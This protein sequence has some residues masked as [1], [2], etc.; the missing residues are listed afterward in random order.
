MFKKLLLFFLPFFLSHL[1]FASPYSLL[2]DE[3]PTSFHN[4]NVINGQLNLC[5]QDTVVKGPTPYPIF[6]TYTS[7]NSI[8]PDSDLTI[9]AYRKGWAFGGGWD[10]L[11]HTHILHR[12]DPNIAGPLVPSKLYITEKNGNLIEY[13][14]IKIKGKK[15]RYVSQA[16]P[17]ISGDFSPRND[18]SKNQLRVN[19]ETYTATLYR[20]DGSI[21]YFSLRNPEQH[22]YFYFWLLDKEILPNKHQVLYTYSDDKERN[23]LSIELKNP[24]GELTYGSLQFNPESYRDEKILSAVTSDGTQLQYQMM[25]HKWQKYLEK[26]HHSCLPTEYFQYRDGRKKTGARV[27]SASFANAEK[28]AISYYEPETKRKEKK[29]AKHIDKID[30]QIDK[31]RQ[32]EIPNPETGKPTTFAIFSYTPGCTK[33]QDC[34]QNITKY[35][36]ED[37]LLQSVEYYLPNGEL[38]SSVKFYW[39]NKHLISKTQ[40]GPNGKE[41]LSKHFEYDENGSVIHEE[42]RGNFTGLSSDES[43]IKTYEY[44]PSSYL[45]KSTTSE[46]ITTHFTYHADTNL[47]TSKILSNNGKILL[48]EFF[49]YDENNILIQEVSDDGSSFSKEDLTDVTTRTLKTNYPDP[50][51]G[52][53]T[54]VKFSYQDQRTL[55]EIQIA[56]SEYIYSSA[57]QVIAETFFDAN[58]HKRFTIH[59]EYNELG[60]AICKTTPL[61]RLNTYTYDKYGNLRSSKEVGKQHKILSYDFLGRPTESTS[62]AITSSCQYDIKGRLLTQIDQKENRTKQS[63]DSF[64]HCLQTELPEALDEAA[65]IYAPTIQMEYDLQGNLTSYTNPRSEKTQTEYNSRRHPLKITYADGSTLKHTYNLDGTLEKTIHLDG[66]E[67]LYTYD[68]FQRKTSKIIFSKEKSILSEETWAYDTFHLLEYTDSRGATTRYIYDSASRKISE[69]TAGRIISYSYDSLGN[70]EQTESNGKVQIQK[71]ND[72]GEIVEQWEESHDGVRENHMSFQYNDEGQ[73]IQAIRVTSKEKAKDSFAYDAQGRLIKHTDP[74][75]AITTWKYNE[76]YIN[77]LGQKVLQKTTINPNGNRS[78]ETFDAS[79]RLVSLE[80]QNPL[81]QTISHEAYLYDRA[82][83]IAQRIVTVFDKIEPIQTYK[84]Q[85]LYNSRG[86]LIEEIEEGDKITYY[87]YGPKGRI[88]QKTLPS[89]ESL[90]YQYDGL[91]R[92]IELKNEDHSLHYSYSYDSHAQII[93]AHDHNQNLTWTQFYNPLGEMIGEE[94]PS[95]FVQKWTYDKSGRCTKIQLPDSSSIEYEYDSLH[96]RAVLRKSKNNSLLYTH[97]YSHFDPN[98]RVESEAFLHNLGVQTTSHNIKERPEHQENPWDRSTIRYDLSGLVLEI[99]STLFGNTPYSYDNLD[100]LHREGPQKYEFDSLGNPKNDT[101][102]TLNQITSTP[103]TKLFYDEDGNLTR[104]HK[105]DQVTQYQFDPLGRLICIHS[106]NNKRIHFKYDPFDRLYSKQ[107]YTAKEDSWE[108]E[109]PQFYLY[110]KDIEIGTIA[111]NLQIQS[112]KVLGLGIK[113][114]IGAAIALEINSIPYLPLHDFYGNIVALVSTDGALI[115]QHKLDAFGKNTSSVSSISPW[116][117]Q[118]KRQEES[119]IFFGA[120]FYSPSLGRFITPDPAGSI[121][122]PN[123][124][125]FLQNSPPNR[126]DLFGFQSDGR[127]MLSVQVSTPSIKVPSIEGLLIPCKIHTDHIQADAFISSNLFHK[128]QFTPEEFQSGK[129]N[130]LDHFQDLFPRDGMSISLI[131]SGNGICTTRFEA[132][133]MSRTILEK[134]PENP[135]FLFIYNPTHGLRKD[136]SRTASELLGTE[137]PMISLTRQVMVA[138]SESLYKVNPE[139]LWFHLPHSEGGAISTYAIEGMTDEQKRELKKQMIWFG[140]APAYPIDDRLVLSSLNVY[141]ERDPV[142]GWIGTLCKNYPERFGK[143]AMNG[144]EFNIKILPRSSSFFRNPS[145]LSEH[146]YHGATLQNELNKEIKGLRRDYG[147]YKETR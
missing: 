35:Y 45:L 87:A 44:Y 88:I 111:P 100:Q 59:T 102:N 58:D 81:K 57:K 123:L 31:V 142:T 115:E 109:A 4:V 38:H 52:L 96:M 11:P 127:E 50:E 114:D 9:Q 108:V 8:Q 103:N 98:G 43:L 15:M 72:E 99:G 10:L 19:S 90:F 53:Y 64:G 101:T 121:D 105:T 124:Y 48:R 84:T 42:L 92:L 5:M 16:K 65:T 130:L 71:H 104:E 119:L 78:R 138:L 1:L 24:K 137:T 82:G 129:F 3:D 40:C 113:G 139:A 32:L 131:T 21:S 134:I 97:T 46:D 136:V 33:V 61:G 145:A 67:E 23:L 18:P 41:V 60:K 25:V 144:K 55:A 69:E 89:G 126:L 66:T 13:R 12:Y 135:L 147:F 6:R 22:T 116:G 7:G 63:Y 56:R 122:S 85:W 74:E 146:S 80:K 77:S 141:S 83:N 70:L 107:V 117:F 36:H 14:R 34:E 51:T 2:E 28:L 27:R 26:T 79:G 62:E 120:R 125:L 94:A 91:D 128:I 110:D 39:E 47:P 54:C 76:N 93:K 143:D 133:E 30:F 29:Y 132:H 49:I 75:E 118:S 140:L 106:P 95:G 17:R 37:D 68:V 20:P 73:R 86:L 112:L